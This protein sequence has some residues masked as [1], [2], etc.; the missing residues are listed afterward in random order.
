MSLQYEF[1]DETAA[2]DFAAKVDVSLGY[3]CDGIS[4]GGGV[5]AP[6]ESAV[7]ATFAAPEKHPTEAKWA[8]PLAPEVT[9][10]VDVAAVQKLAPAVPRDATWDAVTPADA[11]PAKEGP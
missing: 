3:P 10:I 1:A 6:P 4:V 2:L 9:K 8:Y 7:T 5:H 11:E